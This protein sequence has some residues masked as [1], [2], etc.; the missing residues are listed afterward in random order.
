MHDDPSLVRVVH[1][2]TSF[3]PSR[4]LEAHADFL[5]VVKRIGKV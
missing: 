2:L 5:G 4:L 3:F 1:Q